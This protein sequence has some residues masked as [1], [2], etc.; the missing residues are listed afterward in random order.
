M[1]NKIEIFHK[2]EAFSGFI[3]EDIELRKKIALLLSPFADGYL[4][5]PKY[6]IGAWDGRVPFYRVSGSSMLVPKGLLFYLEELFKENDIE[7]SIEKDTYENITRAEVDDFIESLEIPFNPYEY[8]KQCVYESLTKG[9]VTNVAATGSGKSLM[10]Y[11]LMRYMLQTDRTVMI[12]VPNIML[13]N[14][15]YSDFKEYGFKDIDS[16]VQRIGGE[17]KDKEITK[18]CVITTWQSQYKRDN[19]FYDRDAIIIDEC[20]GVGVDS[21]IKETILPKAIK[22]KYRWGFTGT[23]PKSEISRLSIFSALGAPNRVINAQGLIEAGLATPVQIKAILLHYNQE[24]SE[25]VHRQKSYPKE[26]EFMMQH[27][28]RNDVLVSIINKISKKGNA[29][30]LYSKIAHGDFLLK[31]LIRKKTGLD[32]T[33]FEVI[34]E[35][36]GNISKLQADTKYFVKTPLTEAVKKTLSKNALNPSNFVE[37]DSLNIFCVDGSINSSE[38]ERIR[39][40]LEHKDDAIVL[41]TLKTFSTGINVRKLHSLVLASSTKSE[42]TI[43]QSIGRIMRLHNTKEK[44]TVYDIVD[45]ML[46][47]RGKENYFFKHFGERFA[48][49]SEAGYPIEQVEL[50]L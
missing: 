21:Q 35:V 14:Q 12:I 31:L 43:G 23:L 5:N 6:K 20:H 22:A 24:D 36:K 29:L 48:E 9:R 8:Q 10:I 26:E 50:G 1:S 28:K 41:A 45:V 46:G 37:L 40:L 17:H 3:V 32:V 7:Y 18:A 42:I 47:K 15:I 19:E 13:V 33:S 2:N 27:L 4:W 30:V 39:V 44:V 25:F 16:Y 11:M 38:R 34:R 49:Y